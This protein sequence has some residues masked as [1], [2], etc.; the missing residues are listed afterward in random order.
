[1]TR[2]ESRVAHLMLMRQG[3]R[4]RIIGWAGDLTKEVSIEISVGRTKIN[5]ET[6]ADVRKFLDNN[7]PDGDT[8]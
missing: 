2:S 7:Q 3:W 5:L 8:K 1:M 4:S 6:F